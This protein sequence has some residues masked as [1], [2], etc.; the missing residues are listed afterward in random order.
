MYSIEHQND[1]Y[2]GNGEIIQKRCYGLR[3]FQM[4]DIVATAAWLCHDISCDF[5]GSFLTPW[6]VLQCY[7]ES[8]LQ[9]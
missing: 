4:H 1:I 6:N 2:D 9:V 3:N 5:E 8:T 7:L